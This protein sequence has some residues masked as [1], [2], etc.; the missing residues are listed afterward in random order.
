MRIYLFILNEILKAFN[1]ILF[2][3]RFLLVVCEINSG[4][5]QHFDIF[6]LLYS[7]TYNVD[8]SDRIYFELVDQLTD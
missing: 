7:L 4:S 3:T 6:S 8:D 1:I 2:S 5:I